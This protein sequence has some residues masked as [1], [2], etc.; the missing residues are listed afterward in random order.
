MSDLWGFIRNVLTQGHAQQMDYDA[1]KYP[2]GYEEFC[3][4]F[5][6]AARERVTELEAIIAKRGANGKLGNKLAE[7]PKCPCCRSARHEQLRLPNERQC[8]D[9]NCVWNEEKRC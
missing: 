1:G 5:E 4:H 6:E 7:A 2:G 9:C 8:D 3:A